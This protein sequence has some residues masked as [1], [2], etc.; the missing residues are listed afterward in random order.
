MRARVISALLLVLALASPALAEDGRGGGAPSLDRVLPQIRRNTPGTFYDAEGPFRDSA[1]QVRYRIKWMTPDGRIIWFDADAYTGRVL[2]YGGARQPE[3]HFRDERDEHPDR[4]GN[5]GWPD[6]DRRDYNGGG[7]G[8][9]WGRGGWSHGDRGG[10][11][12]RRG[13]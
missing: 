3:S 11:G 9:D 4:F 7:R 10:R 5:R 12:D 8:G 6:D 2:G 13:R 1:G